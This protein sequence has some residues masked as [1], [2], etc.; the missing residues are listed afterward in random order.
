MPLEKQLASLRAT[1][2]ALQEKLLEF[3]QSPIAGSKLQ[4]QFNWSNNTT[5]FQR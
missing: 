5:A 2:T 3:Q 4:E 1:F